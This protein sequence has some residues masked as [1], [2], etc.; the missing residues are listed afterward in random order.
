[1][2][3]RFDMDWNKQDVRKTT[4]FTRIRIGA[5]GFKPSGL[6]FTIDPA[7]PDVRGMPPAPTSQDQLPLMQIGY[8][9][10]TNLWRLILWT[11]LTDTGKQVFSEAFVW[12]DSTAAITGVAGTGLWPSDRAQKPTLLLN[13]PGGFI[14]QTANANLDVPMECVSATAGDFDNDMD[15]DLYLACRRAAENIVNQLWENL[16]NGTF[17]RVD[18]AAGAGGP[19]GIALA[20]GAGTADTAVTGDYNADGFLDLFVTNGFN[21]RP[22]GHGG[23]NRLFRNQGNGNRWLQF[24]LVARQS[25]RDATGARVWVTAGGVKQLREQNGAYHRWSQDAKRLHFGL[26]G[27]TTATVRVEWPGGSSQTFTGVATN[28]LYRL[29][30]G[31][32]L[33]AIQPGSAA[34]YQCGPPR[35]DAARDKGVFIWRD[36]PSGEWRMKTVAGGG[37]AVYAGTITSGAAY[38]SV[39]GVGLNSYDKLDATTDPGR[40]SFRFSTVGT[41]SDGVN[42][43]PQDGQS[44]CLQLSTPSGLPVF[45][46]PFRKSLP[47]PL[48]LDTRGTCQ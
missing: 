5:G 10:A 29:T 45:Y 15:V 23:S 26:A 46:G 14:D 44:A 39:K 37:S 27:A 16:G 9:P 35:I 4:D 25:E 40:I 6:P 38:R 34:P 42:F 43:V 41:S 33:Q 18:G 17:R 1:G 30:E 48:D 13:Y 19:V 7:N 3:V 11:Q 20:G 8:E 22:I 28:R 32:G 36:C 12:V 2:K 47:T 24:D 21:L 31:G